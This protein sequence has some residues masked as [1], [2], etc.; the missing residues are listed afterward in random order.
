MLTRISLGLAL[1]VALPAWSQVEPSA[2]GPP[3]PLEDEMRTP[4]PVSGE[5]Y[6]STTNSEARSNE[7]RAGLNFQTAYDDNVLGF[8]STTPVAD[9]SYSFRPSIELD[10]ITPRL[11]QTLNYS[12]GF[13][14]YQHTSARN[15]ADQNASMDLQYRLSP[16]AAI[17]VRDYF[18]K[19]TNV[20]NQPDA[21][22]SGSTQSLTE[23]VVAPFAN[24][25]G[26]VA[27][28]EASYQFSANRMIGAGGISSIVNYL[29]PAE[30]S[31]LS[32]S[33]LRGGSV[34]YNLRLSSAQYIG[35]IYQYS[36]MKSDFARGDSETQTNTI[37]CFYTLYLDRALSI[38]VSGGPQ[39]F[40]VVQSS[41][42]A[43]A[44]WTPALTASIGWQRSRTNLAVSYSRT[45]TGAGGLLGAFQSNSAN[46]S[47]RLQLTRTWT[48]G[49][50]TTY[51]NFKN[52]IP[53]FL[54]SNSGGHTISGSASVQHSIGEHFTT[55]LGYARLDQSYHGV[56][57]LSA[58]PDSDR[59]Y[60]SVSYQLKKPLG[61]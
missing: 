27:S 38:S 23:A 58:D 56:A 51:A 32:N 33:N 53:L 37:Y 21:G 42:S 57:A 25:L 52:V 9:F 61:R 41:L 40:D 24:Q 47:A 54:A 16:H 1:L 13:T 15:E 26:N 36:K 44:S 60:I 4:P 22:V 45:V 50:T 48:L 10:R 11:S 5:A 12:P 17:S 35:M 28:A 7:L 43:S 18:E 34:F 8:A 55:E 3:P 19:S 29:N 59:A 20:F 49:L 2:T 31:G 14:I 39:H 46:A 30:A 6:P